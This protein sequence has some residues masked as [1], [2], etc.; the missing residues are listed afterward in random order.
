[1]MVSYPRSHSVDAYSTKLNACR[2]NS[3]NHDASKGEQAREG[4]QYVQII[5]MVMVRVVECVMVLV[6]MNLQSRTLQ[7]STFMNYAVP[8]MV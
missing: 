4:N 1:M 7:S 2:K 6:M 8:K 3:N 5:H